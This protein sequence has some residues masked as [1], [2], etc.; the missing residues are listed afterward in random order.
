MNISNIRK[1]IS[2]NKGN[3]FAFKFKGSRN[4]VDEFVGYIVEAY[5]SIFTIKVTDKTNR[6]K[7][8]SYNDIL[9]N[10]LEMKEILLKK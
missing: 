9:I 6:I 1:Y 7:S 3:T 5:H 8:F 2:K 4:Q 10:N